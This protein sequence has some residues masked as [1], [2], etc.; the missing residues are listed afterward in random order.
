MSAELPKMRQAFSDWWRS[1]PQD[2]RYDF[3]SEGRG[4]KKPPEV[5]MWAAWQEAARRAMERTL[6]I[7]R[8]MEERG[9]DA[10]DCAE[11]IEDAMRSLTHE[12]E[13]RHG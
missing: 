7:C 2:Q 9:Y 1:L 13:K 6:S 3:D 4:Y 8:Q 5:L 12:S 10:K 11:A